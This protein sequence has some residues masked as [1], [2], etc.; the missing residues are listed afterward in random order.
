MIRGVPIT[1]ARF[2][3]LSCYKAHLETEKHLGAACSSP[4]HQIGYSGDCTSS[5]GVCDVSQMAV[6]LPIGVHSAYRTLQVTFSMGVH[7]VYRTLRVTLPM[8]VHS[9]YPTLRV[10][11]KSWRHSI[12]QAHGSAQ[13]LPYFASYPEMTALSC[14]QRRVGL[15]NVT[16]QAKKKKKSS[17]PTEKVWETLPKKQKKKKKNC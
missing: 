2:L 16:Q 15:G 14:R 6:T 5:L 7:S 1:S 12:V 3:L 10:T 13:C 9:R 11:R 17:Y 8:G 4:Q